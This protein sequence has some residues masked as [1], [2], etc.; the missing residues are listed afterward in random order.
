MLSRY[1]SF[2][3]AIMR[4][5]AFTLI[6]LLVV[7]AIIAI[8]A[9]LLL[10][11]LAAA[12]E[13]A[14][15][16]SCLTNMQ[17]ISTALVSY[18]SDY[19]EYY[20]S[21]PCWMNAETA[22]IDDN[23][24]Y[25]YTDNRYGSESL[26]MSSDRGS[27]CASWRMVGFG[28]KS[29]PALNDWDVGQLNAAP[30]GIGM[31]LT[32]SYLA[33][34]GVFYCP[35]SD[36]MPGDDTAPGA[37]RGSFTKG[38]WKAAGGYSGDVLLSGG[39]NRPSGGVVVTSGW[40]GDAATNTILSHYAYR[41]TW[42]YVEP[43]P[44]RPSW[45]LPEEDDTFQVPGIKPRVN[46]RLG[47]PMFRTVKALGGRAIVSDA[48]SKGG[49]YDIDGKNR[50][51]VSTIEESMTVKGFGIRGHRQAYNV[52]YGD[53][54]ASIYGDPQESII[55]HTQGYGTV[56]VCDSIWS[57]AQNSWTDAAWRGMGSTVT[58]DNFK[59]TSLAIW[60][61]FDVSQGIDVTE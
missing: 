13:K 3:R 61:G 53:G 44:F 45:W 32:S 36:N 26:L 50:T 34:A 55:W 35:S 9:A 19:S 15:R 43:S 41:N 40:G 18:T 17:Q 48:F 16:T 31:L 56:G 39:W 42:T 33:D 29:G 21:W 4:R 1:H 57:L 8:L 2:A 10:P 27:Y 30:M 59:H 60:H 11:A 38:H 20:P 24:L 49:S 23:P 5:Y 12:R 25:F 47:Q 7:I 14:R 37:E 22:P 46:V 6:E 52:A 58:T 54:H 51:S 28:V